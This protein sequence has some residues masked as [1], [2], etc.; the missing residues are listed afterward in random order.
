VALL[1]CGLEA[2]LCDL[3]EIGVAFAVFILQIRLI[4]IKYDNLKK[5]F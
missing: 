4:G 5:F 2:I 1:R 3:A